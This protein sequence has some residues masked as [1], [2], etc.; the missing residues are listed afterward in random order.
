MSVTK[1]Y[2]SFEVAP[3]S[4][5]LGAVLTGIDLSKELGSAQL[6]DIKSALNEFL[7]LLVRDQSLT[8]AGQRN[9]AEHFGPLIPHPYVHGVDE[10]P[11]IFQIV[12]EPGEGYSWDNFYHSDLMFLEHPPMGS[13]LYAEEVPP[14]GADTEFCN[15]Y[16][17]YEA[18]SDGLKQVVDSLRV[19]NESG[20]T[21]Q[22]SAT[23]EGMHEKKNEEGSSVHPLVRVHPDTG[24]KSLYLSPAFSTRFEGMTVTESKPMMDYLYEHAIQSRFGCRLHW[25]KGSLALWDNRVSL[26]HAVADYFGEV[27][28][29]RRVMRRATIQGEVPIPAH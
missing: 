3:I 22:W 11:D 1:Q 18:L 12:R 6:R 2:S 24:R 5:A 28:A 9:F 26:H 27:T 10:D 14:Y 17:A 4:G 16:L 23:Y 15:M 29:H 7:V 20:D 13:A 8:V 25:E 19:V 21:K